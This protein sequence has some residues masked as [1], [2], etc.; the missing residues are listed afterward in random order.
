MLAA[1]PPI[2]I[3]VP[4][5]TNLNSTKISVKLARKAQEGLRL[6][7]ELQPSD[8]DYLGTFSGSEPIDLFDRGRN[9]G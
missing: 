8:N 3:S 2:Q 4:R 5:V 9:C 6:L 7:R 1:Q